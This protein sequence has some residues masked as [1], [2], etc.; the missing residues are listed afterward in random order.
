[1][2]IVT[3]GADDV[4]RIVRRLNL[5][6]LLAHRRDRAGDLRHLLAPHPQSP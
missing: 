1:M 2:R 3:A 6:H 5:Q 4:D